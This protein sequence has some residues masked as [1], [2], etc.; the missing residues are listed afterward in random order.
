MTTVHFELPDALAHEASKAGLLSSA[1]I[2]RFLREQLRAE[3]IERMNK[4]R[5]T[6]AADPIPMMT[7]AEIQAE[8]DAYR[9]E[10]RAAR[11]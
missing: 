6:L 10:Q 3:R 7:A 1:T 4:S 2:E 8:I 11:S 5:A 9:H